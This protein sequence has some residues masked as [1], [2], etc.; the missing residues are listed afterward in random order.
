VKILHDSLLTARSPTHN[1]DGTSLRRLH[2][3]VDRRRHRSRCSERRS[4]KRTIYTGRDGSTLRDAAIKFGISILLSDFNPPC[5]PKGSLTSS[6]A[7][8]AS[9]RN[10][11]SLPCACCRSISATAIPP[12]PRRSGRCPGCNFT[13][14]QSPS[15][16]NNSSGWYQVVSVPRAD[17]TPVSPARGSALRASEAP[18]FGCSP[19]RY[20]RALHLRWSP[21]IGTNLF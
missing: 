7:K 8:S 6:L 14:N 1:R 20:D 15:P 12:S 21:P 13:G 16:L 3:A 11:T 5:C 10:A 9:P 17:A 19:T 2:R 4:R 18:L